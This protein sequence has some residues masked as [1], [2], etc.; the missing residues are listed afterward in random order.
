MSEISIIGAGW[1]GAVVAHELACAGFYCDVFDERPHVAGN[2]HTERDRET[3]IM[4]HVYGPHIFHTSN[5]QVWSYVQ[6]F[7]EFMPFTNRVKAVS[8]GRVYSLPVNLLTIN[9]FFGKTLTPAEARRFLDSL[10][11]H[12][13]QD[14]QT[15]EQQALHF[16][17]REL[18]EAFFAGYT[19]KQWGVEPSELPASILKRLPVR[20]DYN[21][22]YYD[23]RFQGIPVHGYT[24]IIERLLDHKNIRVFLNLKVLPQDAAGY[25]HTFYSGP[26]DAWFAFREGRLRYRTLDFVPERHDGDYQGNPILNYCDADVPWTRITEHKHFTAWESH[27]RT[28][29]FKE[30]SRACEERDTPFYPLRLAKDHQALALYQRMAQQ[31]ARVTF[32]G[33]LATYRYLDMHIVIE[34]ALQ[35]AARF[36]AA[37]THPRLRAE[38]QKREALSLPPEPQDILV[39]IVTLNRQAKL[40]KTLEE[41]RR[42][43]FRNIV[44][45]DNA[46]TDG[47]REYLAAEQGIV[48]IFAAENGGSSGGYN[49]I[50][51]Y[52]IEQTACRWLLTFDD[53]SFPE[54]DCQDIADYLQRENE[55]HRCAY[56]LKVI[57]PDGS[58]CAMNRP[59]HNVLTN[60]PWRHLPREFHIQE[61][62]AGCPVDFA[63]FVGLL[64]PRETVEAV[65]AV[66]KEFFIYSDD[67][68][69]TLSISS[70][71][72]KIFYCPEFVLVHDCN[73]SSRRFQHHDPLRLEKDVIN[74]IVMIREYS[75][76]PNAYIA[77]YVTRSIL[78]NPTRALDIPRAAYKGIS[79]DTRLYKNEAIVPIAA[80]RSASSSR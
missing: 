9:Q 32:V 64:L 70:K 66:S 2:C 4:A 73:R 57:Y 79:A 44:V 41:C 15:F 19:R 50:M 75:R 35:A 63:S 60:N 18:Y 17:G 38:R 69:Y 6:R 78:M 1:S 52:F 59:G 21:D 23:S 76:F 31:E 67:T 62:T 14:P 3:G 22:N 49:R 43:G 47:T 45:V 71:L 26:L 48:K 20:F 10:A 51:H 25:M 55:A 42:R 5:E 27:E 77:L 56:A 68:Y 72:G 54:F 29:I 16:L 74:K 11:D 8:K 58:L 40:A 13:I 46:S 80:A 24:H 53:D 7:D 65:G 37:W 36:K 30:Y 34:E 61:S 12:S 33:R 39:G 28:L